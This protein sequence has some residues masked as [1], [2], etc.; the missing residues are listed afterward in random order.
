MK[1]SFCKQV[2]RNINHIYWIC[3]RQMTS[4]R[5]GLLAPFLREPLGFKRLLFCQSGRKV[6]WNRKLFKLFITAAKKVLALHDIWPTNEWLGYLANSR[7]I[8][9]CH[10]QCK[11]FV[12]AKFA[13]QNKFGLIRTSLK[14]FSAPKIASRSELKILSTISHSKLEKF[15]SKVQDSLSVISLMIFE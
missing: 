1:L 3:S 14:I 8:G 5:S 12:H 9:L 15:K 10:W 13:L 6:G 11:H 7:S 4:H 2:G